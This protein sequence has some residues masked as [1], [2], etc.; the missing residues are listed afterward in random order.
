ME[1]KISNSIHTYS[2]W[3]DTKDPAACNTNPSVYKKFTRDPERTPFQ[4]DGSSNAGFSTADKTWLPVNPNYVDLN[5]KAEKV[6]D[7]SHFKFYQRLMK[8]RNLD[9]FKFGDLKVQAL[10]RFVFAYVRELLDNN[11]YVVVINLGPDDEHVDL[12]I[13]ASLKD[14]L[15]VVAASPTSSYEEG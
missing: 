2:S 13:F 10:S 4:W 1:D 14:K 5:L 8:L 9:T 7:K 3:E 6:A 15:K 12:K 11:T